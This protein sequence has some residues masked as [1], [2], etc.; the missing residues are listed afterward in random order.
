MARSSSATWFSTKTR[1]GS[2]ISAA[3]K[4][5]SSGSPRSSGPGRRDALAPAGLPRLVL[6]REPDQLGVERAHPQLAFGARLVE[7]AK[8]NRHVAANDYRAPASLDD[9]HLHAPGVARRRDEPEPGKQLE[10]AVDRHV[11][12]AGRIDPLANGVVVLVPRVV[13]LPTLDVNRLAGKETVAAAVI[14]MQ[15]GVDDEVD[16]GEVEVLPVQWTYAGIEIGHRRVQLRHAGVDQHARIG[17]IDDVHVD[18]HPLALG[19]E[20]RNEDG[21]DG[22][23]GKSGHLS[24]RPEFAARDTRS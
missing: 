3:P 23:R 5:S 11:P 24:F 6:V 18:R 21:R 20:V 9:D 4:E 14:E 12:H 16:A 7:L 13:Q 15:M 17:M 1:I 22:D 10:F 8:P 2:A 19:A